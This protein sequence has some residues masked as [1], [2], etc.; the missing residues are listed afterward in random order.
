MPQPGRAQVRG[1]GRCHRARPTL[2]SVAIRVRKV[3][4]TGPGRPRA[5]SRC[6]PSGR[7]RQ[8]GSDGGSGLLRS[9]VGEEPGIVTS[10]TLGAASRVARSAWVS[11]PSPLLAWTTQ[12]GVPHAASWAPKSRSSTTKAGPRRPEGAYTGLA[13]TTRQPGRT[14][15]GEHQARRGNRALRGALYISAFASL[16]RPPA[17]PTTRAREPKARPTPPPDSSRAGSRRWHWVPLEEH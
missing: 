4:P 6:R 13:P 14:I 1:S 2:G 9:L 8:S 16:K 7:L 15:K 5:S 12:T 11:P 17:A 3:L 10:V